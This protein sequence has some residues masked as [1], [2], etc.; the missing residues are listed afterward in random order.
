MIPIERTQRQYL[1]SIYFGIKPARCK[2][3]LSALTTVFTQFSANPRCVT[4]LVVSTLS[5]DPHL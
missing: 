5:A 4:P 1:C 2:L 3:Q